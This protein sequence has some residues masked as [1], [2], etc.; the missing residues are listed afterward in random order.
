MSQFDFTKEEIDNIYKL[1]GKNVRKYRKEKQLTQLDL[2]Y[3][4]G[5]KSV[6]LVSAS[7]PCS[8]NKHFNIEHLYKISKILDIP[9]SSFFKPLDSK[10]S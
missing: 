7:E 8:N 4:M 9:M 5:C 1:I 3:E 10:N 2:A 6:S